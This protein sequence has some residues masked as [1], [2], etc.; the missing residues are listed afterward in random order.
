MKSSVLTLCFV[1]LTCDVS[2]QMCRKFTEEQLDVINDAYLFGLPHDYGY[3]LA[4]IAIKESF[5]G[6]RILR[7]NPNDPSTGVT[8][9]LFGTLKDLSGLNHWD[10]ID[11]AQRL[12]NDDLRSFAYTIQKLDSIQGT[13]WNKWKRYNGRGPAAEAYARDIQVTI[14]NLKRCGTI[15]YAPIY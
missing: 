13:F 4:A 11:E 10:A 3:T 7:Y 5:L 15:R 1:L 9:I 6:D 8:H 14:V 12:I 2:A